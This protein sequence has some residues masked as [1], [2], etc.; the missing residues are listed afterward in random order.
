MIVSSRAFKR[1]EPSRDAKLLL[2]VCEGGDTEPRYFEYFANIDSRV[3][4]EIIAAEHDAD[5]SPTGLWN[6]YCAMFEWSPEGDRPRPPLDENT[7]E[8]WFVIDTDTWGDKIAQLRAN[9]ASRPNHH[10]VVSNPCFEVWLAFHLSAEQQQ[11]PDCHLSKPWKA[12]LND[13]YPGGFNPTRYPLLIRQAIDNA[14]SN[15]AE[16]DVHPHLGCTNVFRLAKSIYDILQPKLDS[17]YREAI[18]DDL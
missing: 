12:H 3:Q 13:L 4:I 2:I 6:T 11:F 1:E 14:E 15:Y 17:A 7:D 10:V 9:V 8:V 5:N 18:K 16:T